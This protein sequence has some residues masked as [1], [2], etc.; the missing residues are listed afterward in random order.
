M[1]KKKE[2]PKSTAAVDVFFDAAG[3]NLG[4]KKMCYF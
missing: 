3:W 1:L 4:C 2:L